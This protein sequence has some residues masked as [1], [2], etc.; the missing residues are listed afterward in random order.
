MLV[1]SSLPDFILKLSPWL[2]DKSGNSL[3]LSPPPP[4]VA[5][6]TRL[7]VAWEFIK[8][9]VMSGVWAVMP[10]SQLLV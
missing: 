3:A 9:S 4:G 8:V 5:W 1:S 10:P 6:G 7:G 2:Q